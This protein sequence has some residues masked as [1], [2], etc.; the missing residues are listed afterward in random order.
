MSHDG[1]LSPAL[2]G[3][4]IDQGALA[5][6]FGAE[7]TAL[8]MEM[9]ASADPLADAAIAALNS[10]QAGH[11]AILQAGL[12]E[13]RAS[14]SDSPEAID[15]LLRQAESI[16]PWVDPERIR[17]GAE[18][19]LSI[20]ALW[21]SISLGP[22][23]LAHTYS[24]PAIASVLMATGNLD[25][26][27]PRR[28]LET[29]VWQQQTLRPG[30]LAA[31][32]PGYIHTLQVRILHA[33]VRAGLLARGW[34]TTQRGMPISQLDMLRTWLDFTYVP[35]NALEKIGIEYDAAEFRDLY[36]VWQLVAHLLGIEERYYRRMTDQASG[37][38]M[39]AL[40]DAAAGEPDQ[41]AVTLT[42]K[43]LDA[44]AQRLGPALG[45]PADAAVGLMHAFC[46]LFHGDDFADKLGVQ[47]NWWSGLM[48][49]FA[50]SNRYQRLLE[51]SDPEVRQ[52]KINA[53]LAAFDQQI[54][55]LEGE[56][57]YQHN[58]SAY[59]GAGMPKTLAGA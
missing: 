53:T 17:R 33:R 16:P 9:A 32:A 49:V 59:S 44:A 5:A 22:G 51:R 25:A 7:A 52:R 11:P 56:T 43:M 35:F 23:S 14:L 37:A 26:Q 40:I 38:E 15:A 47:R 21:T 45:M 48:P 41:A 1:R 31:G 2:P 42:A 27:S 10:G 3:R 19:Y 55:A 12:R 18:T 57:T 54:A 34:D 50:N 24:S 36:H 39:L 20:G 4:A 29:A 13:G 58:L 30:G 8:V 28:L 6:R 46:R